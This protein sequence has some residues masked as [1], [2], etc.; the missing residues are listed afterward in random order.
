[1]RDKE[2]AKALLDL[3]ASEVPAVDAREQTQR[4]LDRDRRR[5]KILTIVT[6]IC[7]IGSAGVLYWF[8]ISWFA[9]YSQLQQGDGLPDD[10]VIAKT[11]EFTL[12]LAGTIEGLIFALLSTIL[13]LTFQR[14]ATLRQINANLVRI[15]E[16]LDELRNK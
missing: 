7:W 3:G 2:L 16:Q 8:M 6:A 10:P 5:V 11:F 14:R 13:L 12:H 9:L 15:S 4:I 1:M